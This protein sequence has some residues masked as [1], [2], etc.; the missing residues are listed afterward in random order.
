MNIKINST[1]IEKT[2]ENS[3]KRI[4]TNLS[5]MTK[6]NLLLDE[7][8]NEKLRKLEEN[9]L[10]KN[11]KETKT[12]VKDLE[13]DSKNTNID[14]EKNSRKNIQEDINFKYNSNKENL[15]FWNPPE[16]QEI[17]LPNSPLRKPDQVY[18]SD[19]ERHLFSNMNNELI[20]KFD[21][22]ADLEEG[23]KKLNQILDFSAKSSLKFKVDYENDFIR[24]NFKNDT[25]YDRHEINPGKYKISQQKLNTDYKKEDELSE[26]KP[27]ISDN[28]NYNPNNPNHAANNLDYHNKFFG[29]EIYS[30]PK[31]NY[32]SEKNYTDTTQYNENKFSLNNKNIQIR[33]HLPKTKSIEI[34]K[35]RKVID[36]DETKTVNPQN[37][38]FFS[39][40][41]NIN[42]NINNTT[43]PR[44]QVFDES[45]EDMDYLKNLL[46]KTKSDLDNLNKNLVV[47]ETPSQYSSKKLSNNFN[48]DDEIEPR[49]PPKNFQ[50]Y[51]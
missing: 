27:Y 18:E 6:S 28:F 32:I 41:T 51:N 20:K 17:N 15:K 43:S 40:N 5:S 49:A 38:N 46:L 26:P 29:E 45:M 30:L 36:I 44:E 13:N 4:T 33:E 48:I 50:F 25:E 24:D 22:L 7:D 39:N 21:N 34:N 11:N 8:L 3:E 10:N 35:F 9:L 1:K 19:E 47:K 16:N 12:F 31:V 37:Y 42:M 14:F 2:S 23:M